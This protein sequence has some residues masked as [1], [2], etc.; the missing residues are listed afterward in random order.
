MWHHHKSSGMMGIVGVIAAIIG[1]LV[2]AA[3]IYEIM[4][5]RSWIAEH[6]PPEVK[7]SLPEPVSK[8]LE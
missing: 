6:I 2:V 4:M 1:L 8:A 3:L 5:N 7:Q